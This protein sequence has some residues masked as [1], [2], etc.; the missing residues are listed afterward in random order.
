MER[1]AGKKNQYKYW[2]LAW[3]RQLEH[4]W[5]SVLYSF[6]LLIWIRD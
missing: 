3:I 2:E 6:R 4:W 5:I 1:K